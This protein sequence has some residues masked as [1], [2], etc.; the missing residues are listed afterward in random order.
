[1]RHT[2][3]CVRIPTLRQMSI[4]ARYTFSMCTVRLWLQRVKCDGSQSWPASL[5]ECRKV[6]EARGSLFL[7]R[8]IECGNCPDRV[9]ASHQHVLVQN[10]PLA[11]CCE[12]SDRRRDLQ[13]KAHCTVQRF[14]RTSPAMSLVNLQK[15][16]GFSSNCGTNNKRLLQ[17]R[18]QVPTQKTRCVSAT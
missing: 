5:S 7:C 14:P 12:C 11:F 10:F 15:A 9:P 16:Y 3:D 4:P 2:R 8:G 6:L 17:E 1:M 13:V 18:P